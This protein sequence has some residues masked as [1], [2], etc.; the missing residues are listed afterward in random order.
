MMGENHPKTTEK[1]HLKM[2]LVMAAKI[3]T[4]QY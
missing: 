1:M 2:I 3:H 4:N